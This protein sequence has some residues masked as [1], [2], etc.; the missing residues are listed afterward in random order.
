MTENPRVLVVDD[1]ASI[2]RNLAV[3]M[4]QRGY[5]VD[6]CE[7][8]LSA[9]EKIEAA[10]RSGSP[11]NYVVLDIRLPDIDGLQLLKM[12]KDVYPDLPVLVISGYGDEQTGERVKE[13]CGSAYL[14]KPFEIEALEAEIR[15]IGPSEEET[16]VP[17]PESRTEELRSQSAYVFLRGRP[18]ADLSGCFNALYFAEGVFYCDAVTGDWDIVLL[19]QAPD[20]RGIR[21]WVER[22]VKPLPEIEQYEIHHS[23]RPLL[24]KDIESFLRHY[25]LMQAAEGLDE[26]A[27]D[28]R[29]R[30]LLSAYVLLEI[31]RY[32]V[33]SLYTTYYFDEDVVY[34]DMTD[35]CAMA[36]LLVQGRTCDAI[37]QAVSRLRSR[38][39]VL[40]ARTLNI[41]KFQGV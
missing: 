30:Q 26:E 15:R 38:P 17:R 13:R 20:R 36:I 23:E 39:G 31:D 3:G 24:G 35:D 14:D 41:V 19:V 16:P 1:E 27:G 29:K 11:H 2:R 28:R 5:E 6:A 33:P 9:L 40:R 7:M 10:R 8:G 25:E 18:D 4:A 34:C 22:T 32:C 12:I 37:R 21:E